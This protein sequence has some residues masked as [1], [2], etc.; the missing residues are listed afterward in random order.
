MYKHL[1]NHQIKYTEKSGLH[2]KY[3]QV[4]QQLIFF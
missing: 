3:I 2:K 4:E 1:L